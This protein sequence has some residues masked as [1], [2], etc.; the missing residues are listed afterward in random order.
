MQLSS[1]FNEH[2]YSAFREEV[3]VQFLKYLIL[4]NTDSLTQSVAEFEL[5]LIK[6]KLGENIESTITWEYEPYGVINGL[7]KNTLS[8]EK[9]EKGMYNT[10]ISYT[11]KEELFK[12][13][14][15]SVSINN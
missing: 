3:F 1:F 9:S 6:L 5:S 14:N 4:K 15:M 2:R 11:N 12:V 7:L 10:E 8:I 13:K